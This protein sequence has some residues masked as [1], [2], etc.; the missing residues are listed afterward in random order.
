M[1]DATKPE[2][3]TVDVETLRRVIA[4]EVVSSFSRTEAAGFAEIEA[5]YLANDVLERI[6]DRR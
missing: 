6:R 3:I 2:T 1:S 5:K 4:E